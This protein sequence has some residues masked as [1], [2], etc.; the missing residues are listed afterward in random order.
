MFCTHSLNHPPATSVAVAA[1][2]AL[3]AGG[4]PARAA[5][6]A[7]IRV[8]VFSGSATLTEDIGGKTDT[9]IFFT[10][11]VRWSL[12]G[13][14]ERLL[15]VGETAKVPVRISV[16][17]SAHGVYAVLGPNG[18]PTQHVSYDCSSHATRVQNARARIV[19]SPA[20][21]LHL[22]MTLINPGGLNAGAPTC[23]DK[24]QALTFEF[25]TGTDWIASQLKASGVLTPVGAPAAGS[26]VSR[27][28][29]LR[30][31]DVPNPPYSIAYIERAQI[32]FR[33]GFTHLR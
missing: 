1:A 22:T 6:P 26:P 31:H 14:V 12:P 32:S 11:Q 5:A 17:G 21:V 30:V 4:A 16:R 25:P 18:G 7:H 3:L 2:L 33:L 20:G 9:P 8:S 15:R 23:T 27:T 19:K 29:P 10:E 24:E 28:I 13:A